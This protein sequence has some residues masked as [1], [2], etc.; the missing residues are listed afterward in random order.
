VSLIQVMNVLA[1]AA[2]LNLQARCRGCLTADRAHLSI[3][4]FEIW[5]N[6]IL[7]SF[8]PVAAHPGKQCCLR[9]SQLLTFSSP[10]TFTP[11]REQG[12]QGTVSSDR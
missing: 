8:E 11:Q 1:R 2:H 10:T 6:R 12:A 7:R 4:L 5:T 3:E 9:P